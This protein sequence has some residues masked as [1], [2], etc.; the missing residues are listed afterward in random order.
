M[1]LEVVLSFWRNASAKRKRLYSIGLVF[2]VTI[3]VMALGSSTTLSQAQAD[4]ISGN[5]N[6]TLNEQLANGNLIPF[7]F[8][9]NF[10]IALLMFFPLAGAALRLLTLFNTG[11]VLSALAMVNS[12]PAYVAFLGLMATPV[13]WLEFAAYSIAM[14]ESIWLFRQLLHRRWEEL[15]L[16]VMSIGICALVLAIGAVVEVY[17]IT[18]AG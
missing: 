3:L 14:A 5:V 9:N 4:F 12:Y 7:I 8:V 16:V 2:V 18:S 13:F 10:Q 17:I 11:I 6:R 15:K 1:F